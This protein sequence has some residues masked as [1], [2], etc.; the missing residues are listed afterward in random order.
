MSAS[1]ESL[2]LSE[3]TTRY[4]QLHPGASI[5]KACIE[6]FSVQHTPLYIQ[7][8]CD[9]VLNYPDQFK[10][11]SKDYPETV[12][13]LDAISEIYHWSV[14]PLLDATDEASLLSNLVFLQ[15]IF[16]RISSLLYT[17]LE[18][19]TGINPSF[20]IA[21]SA[22]CY[23]QASANNNFLVIVPSETDISKIPA[24]VAF[25]QQSRID[26]K[27][28]NVHA[29]RKQLQMAQKGALAVSRVRGSSSQFATVGLLPEDIAIRYPRFGF[30]NHMDWSFCVPVPTPA[31]KDSD[32]DED[33]EDGKGLFEGARLRYLHGIPMIPPVSL[34]AEIS[35]IVRNV[36]RDASEASAITGI[37]RKTFSWRKG[38]ILVFAE[39]G[40]I[41]TEVDN[42]VRKH[43]RGILLTSPIPLASGDSR[44]LERLCNIDGALLLDSNGDCHACGVILDGEIHRG[45]PAPAVTAPTGN[46]I[47]G[48]PARGSRFNSSLLYAVSLAS[49]NAGE[50][51]DLPFLCAV[52]S[53]DGMLDL[54]DRDYLQADMG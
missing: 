4:F 1:V 29:V 49:R 28:E 40:I 43:K 48:S 39:S 32:S 21:L 46:C 41:E 18:E 27:H 31:Q 3:K 24:C 37:I 52:K 14:R 44:L 54:I 25:D 26:L 33:N 13:V 23:E 5:L 45:S 9:Y 34:E 20:I 7:R 42:L 2:S 19:L 12:F 51:L 15:Y 30:S 35:E 10:Q 22:E 38:A 50:R 47:P 16:S 36:F 8:L 6:Y 53:E 11:L 17:R